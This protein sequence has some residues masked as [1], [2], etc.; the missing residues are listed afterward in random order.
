MFC[1]HPAGYYDAILM[2]VRMPV[3]NGLE[4]TRTIRALDRSDA[5]KN[6]YSRIL[7]ITLAFRRRI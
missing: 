1:E 6:N 2:D 7:G 5:E 3:M 4:A